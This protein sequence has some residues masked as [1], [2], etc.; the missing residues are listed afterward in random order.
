L[1]DNPYL[2][3]YEMLNASKR[4]GFI[5]TVQASYEFNKEWDFLIRTSLDFSSESRSQRRP[6]GTN[7]FVDGMYRE[8]SIFAEE[9]NS[10]LLV[11]YKNER[12]DQIKFSVSAGGSTMTNRYRK[13]EL[14][15]DRLLYPGVYSFANSKEVPVSLPYRADYG[16]NS[17][18]ALGT[19]SYNDYLFMDVT[20]RNDWTST[21]A[22]PS[23]SKVKS[24]FYPSV[25]LSAV[26][27]EMFTLPESVS[28]WKLRASVAQVGGG[29][30]TPYLTAYNYTSVNSFPS[31]L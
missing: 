7:K 19:I 11:N 9:Q 18:Y 14:R 5:G 3:A 8:Q 26:F 24:F 13:D 25:N 20:C 12:H 16:V 27:S 17:L 28:F 23:N 30:T 4:H 31:G 15:A 10:D 21:L 22:L 29:G 6:K 2:Q 1:L